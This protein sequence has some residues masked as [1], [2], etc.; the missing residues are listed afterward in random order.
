M[1]AADI[2]DAVALQACRDARLVR[3]VDLLVERTGAPVKVA[4]AK[5]DKLARRGLIDYG[6]SLGTAWVVE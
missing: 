6:V 3:P 2:P 1:K 5:L 4:Y